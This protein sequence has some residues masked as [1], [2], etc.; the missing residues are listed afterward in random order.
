MNGLISRFV[1][2]FLF[3]VSQAETHKPKP[4]K[5][6][7]VYPRHSLYLTYYLPETH[8]PK[9]LKGQFVYPRHS[10]YLTYYYHAP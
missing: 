8:K 9:P 4:L 2:P 3:L 7:F 5:G 6:Q 10:L 1:S